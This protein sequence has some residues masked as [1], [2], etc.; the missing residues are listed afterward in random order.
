MDLSTFPVIFLLISCSG[1]VGYMAASA[2]IWGLKRSHYRLECDV[3]DLQNSLL[4][5]I[6]R[7]AGAASQK[8]K[9]DDEEL[10]AKILE[11]ANGTKAAPKNWWDQ[12]V[13][14]DVR[15]N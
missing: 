2:A 1:I 8:A 7:R 3:T 4:I 11:A 10:A 12:Y 13:H 5:E 9:K 14:P 6:K 15:G